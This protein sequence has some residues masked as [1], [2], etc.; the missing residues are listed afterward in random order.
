MSLAKALIPEFEHETAGLR[1][2]FERVPADRFDY[3]PHP[4]SFSLGDLANHLATIPGWSISTLTLTE[5]DFGL[6]RFGLEE[7]ERLAHF[8]IRVL[9][10][11]RQARPL[12]QTNRPD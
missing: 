7:A 10:N 12:L 5:L 8:L 6:P 4:K 3:R 9:L 1:R 2:V 11:D